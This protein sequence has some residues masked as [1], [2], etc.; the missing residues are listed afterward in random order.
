MDK[1]NLPPSESELLSRS[2]FFATIIGIILYVV[3]DAVVQVLP[4]HYS[5]ISQAESDLAVG[6]YGYIMAINFVN[7]GVLSILFVVAVY[8]S[9]PISGRPKFRTGLAL[10]SFWGAGALVLSVFP[11]DLSG[12]PVT[13]HGAIHLIAA[14]IAFICGAFGILLLSLRFRPVASLQSIRKY[15][16]PISVIAV[17]LCFATFLGLNTRFGGLIEWLFLGSVLLWILIASLYLI[18]PAHVL[19]GRAQINLPKEEQ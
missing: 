2:L 16:L 15:V 17:I 7:R 14:L 3:L 9:L 1:N 13:V 8:N 5:P 18:N 10:I 12:N 11:T 4:P 19:R 6:P